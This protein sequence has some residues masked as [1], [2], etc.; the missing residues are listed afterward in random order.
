MSRIDQRQRPNDQ[1]RDAGD[2]Q[3]AVSWR[4]KLCADQPKRQQQQQHTR[5]QAR[6]DSLEL[7]ALA[8]GVLAEH[9]HKHSAYRPGNQHIVDRARNRPRRRVGIHTGAAAKQ[10]R[11]HRHAP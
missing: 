6:H 5:C 9:G 10:Q 7:A 2:H 11:D 4:K 3:R 8:F 1:Q